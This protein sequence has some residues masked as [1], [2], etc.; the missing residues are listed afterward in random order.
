MEFRGDAQ[1]PPDAPFVTYESGMTCSDFLTKFSDF[2]DGD[3]SVDEVAGQHLEYCVECRRY[4]EVFE[5][6]REL[7]RSLPPLQV[8]EEFVPDL[9]RRISLV[10]ARAGFAEASGSGATAVTAVGMAMLLVLAAWSPRMLPGTTSVD[11]APIVVSEPAPRPLGF[12]TR[13]VSPFR[14]T[15]RDLEPRRPSLWSDPNDLLFQY[16]PLAI[17]AGYSELRTGLD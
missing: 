15:E 8:P 13:G 5:R 4:V 16:S 7:L 6:G 3:D 1:N 10:N 9:R 12:R 11:L 2:V 14:S 17:R